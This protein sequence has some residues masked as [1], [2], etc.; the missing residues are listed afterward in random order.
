MI[1][2][3]RHWAHNMPTP[4]ICNIWHPP[5][6]DIGWSTTTTPQ[7]PPSG[8]VRLGTPTLRPQTSDGHSTAAQRVT[9]Q[10]LNVPMASQLG[11]QN[12]EDPSTSNPPRVQR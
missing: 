11:E 3:W 4:H 5:G 10:L 6:A 2:C 9:R 8:T 12:L 7:A 1:T